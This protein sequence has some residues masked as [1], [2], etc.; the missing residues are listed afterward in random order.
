MA[1]RL[2]TK[3]NRNGESTNAATWLAATR[4][5]LGDGAADAGFEAMKSGKTMMQ[6]P[7]FRVSVSGKTI[8]LNAVWQK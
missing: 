5:L 2:V 8:M 6:A 3:S 7:G 1:V 4:V